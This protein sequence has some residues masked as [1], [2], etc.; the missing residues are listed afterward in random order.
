M[1]GACLASKS[2]LGL[3]D[4]ETLG[5]VVALVFRASPS[6]ANFGPFFAGIYGVWPR[7]TSG[8]AR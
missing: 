6:K 4:S 1:E 3:L 7:W 5:W 2:V 8:I